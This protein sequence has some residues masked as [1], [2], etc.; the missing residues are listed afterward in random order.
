[1]TSAGAVA[2][3]LLY[4]KKKEVQRNAEVAAAALAELLNPQIIEEEAHDNSGSGPAQRDALREY[5]EPDDI[6]AQG[7]QGEDVGDDV[8]KSR[9]V[10]ASSVHRVSDYLPSYPRRRAIPTVPTEARSGAFLSPLSSNACDRDITA[11]R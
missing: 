8:L 7:D 4:T 5:R 9:S 2:T 3:I 1:M 6:P 10:N 11:R